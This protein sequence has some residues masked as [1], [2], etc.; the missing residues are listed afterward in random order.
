MIRNL[1]L[2]WSGT[3]VDDLSCVLEAT[4]HVL[5]REGRPTLTRDQFRAAFRLPFD[6]FYRELL[7]DT[8]AARVEELFHEQYGSS[9]LLVDELPHASSFLEFCRERGLKTFL[10]STLHRG[11]YDALAAR[12]GFSALL[13]KVYVEVLDKRQKIHSLLAENNLDPRETLFV[14]D[15]QHDIETARHGGVFSCAVLTGYNNLDQLRASRPDMIVEHLGELRQRLVASRFQIGPDAPPEPPPLPISTVGAL[16]Y[17][18][19]GEVLMIQTQKWSGL[20]GIPGGKIKYGETALDALHREVL[21]ETGLKLKQVRF[22]TVQDCIESTEFYRR[23]HFLLLIYTAVALEPCEV[24]LNEEAVEFRWVTPEQASLMPLNKPTRILLDQ[25]APRPL[26]PDTIL[27]KELCVHYHVGV[28]DEERAR[29]Q[30]LSLNLE[31]KTDFSRAAASD[32][33]VDTVN[34]FEVSRRLLHFGEGRSWK[35]IET[36]AADI[37]SLILREFAVDS[38]VVE[39][40]KFILPETRAVAVR[41]ERSRI[42]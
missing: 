9:R 28:P 34:Y 2:D 33:I 27:V 7:P 8:P 26:F 29:P 3:L 25:A 17:N 37:A 35:L 5:V 20:W 10:L 31:L 32:S 22:V 13:D 42:E 15:M 39:V 40:E 24:R 4:N 36:L 21:E 6:G 1:I 18:R 30:R 19:L 14:G 23:C 16:I 38:V 41:M 11:H 12:N